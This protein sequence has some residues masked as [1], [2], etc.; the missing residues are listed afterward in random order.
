VAKSRKVVYSTAREVARRERKG[1]TPRRVRPKVLPPT[2]TKA[3]SSYAERIASQALEKSARGHPVPSI[4][5]IATAMLL[6]TDAE[7]LLAGL[8][9]MHF[10]FVVVVAPGLV[11]QAIRGSL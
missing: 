5:I 8:M 10:P 4:V 1:K 6:R 7:L 2:K 3:T 9:G 11:K